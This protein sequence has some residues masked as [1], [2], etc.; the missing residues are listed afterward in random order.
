MNLYEKAIDIINK[1]EEGVGEV[2]PQVP[3]PG[4][5]SYYQSVDETE[6]EGE[7]GPWSYDNGTWSIED[8]QLN[9]YKKDPWGRQFPNS[10]TLAGKLF[11]TIKNS[12]GEITNWTTNIKAPDGKVYEIKIWND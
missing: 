4:N 8:S 12:E 10:K 5:V 9:H 3:S 7:W 1:L 2:P 6:A 11:D